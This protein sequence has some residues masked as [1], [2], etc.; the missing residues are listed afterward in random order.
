MKRLIVIGSLF[1]L[2]GC[3]GLV[4]ELK[5]DPAI[6]GITGFWVHLGVEAS[7]ST[8]GIPFPTLKFGHGTIWRVGVSDEVTIKAGEGFGSDTKEKTPGQSGQASLLIETKNTS[9]AL[10]KMKDL[11]K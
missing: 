8:G 11:Y 6:V 1:L 3:V 5:T 7:P 9:K 10:E 2:S 4:H